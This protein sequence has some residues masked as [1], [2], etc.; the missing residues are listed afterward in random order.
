[1]SQT[2]HE[3]YMQRCLELAANGLR[4]AMPNPSVGSVL[5]YDGRIIGEG[6]THLW[7]IMFNKDIA[8]ECC[9]FGIVFLFYFSDDAVH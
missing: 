3:H 4:E 6:H 8:D 5:V 1:M 9:H 2:P 7:H